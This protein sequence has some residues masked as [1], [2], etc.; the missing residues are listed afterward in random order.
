MGII[1]QS[2]HPPIM[3]MII[4]WNKEFN[5]YKEK[6]LES[7]MAKHKLEGEMCFWNQTYEVQN[8]GYNCGDSTCIVGSNP[9]FRMHVHYNKG[10]YEGGKEEHYR[11][12]SSDILMKVRTS[13]M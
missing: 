12:N 9:F 5:Y 4:V 1:K 8:Q 10:N 7:A 11:R 2:M 3:S 6:P 13:K